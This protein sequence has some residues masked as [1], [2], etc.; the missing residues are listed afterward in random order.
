MLGCLVM[1]VGC[2]CSNDKAA[3]AVEPKFDSYAF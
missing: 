1:V 2:S 3:D